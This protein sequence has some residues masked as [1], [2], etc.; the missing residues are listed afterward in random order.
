MMMNE[1]DEGLKMLEVFKGGRTSSGLYYPPRMSRVAWGLG[2][3]L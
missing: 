1:V 2:V 3:V